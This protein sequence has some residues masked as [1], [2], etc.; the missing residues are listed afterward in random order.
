[1]N[2]E[3][4]VSK[5]V[6]K[7]LGYVLKFGIT[8]YILWRI[9][10]KLDLGVVI[11]SI[12]GQPLWLLL[13]LLLISVL[14][15]GGHC[16]NWA[17]ALRINPLYKSDWKE[18]VNSYLIGQPLRFVLPGGFG[19]AGMVLF[20][21]NSSL[22]ATIL[23]Y[24]M[25]RIFLLWGTLVFASIS[26]SFL[27]V[28]IPLWLRL[29]AIVIV[30]S[31][32]VWIYLILGANRRWRRLR[33]NYV[34][35]TPRILIVQLVIV[36]LFYFQYWLMLQRIMPIK[37]DETVMRMSLTHVISSIPITVAGLG[38]RESFAIHFLSDAGFQ[39]IE[40]VTTTLTIFIIHDI[41]FAL[42]GSVFLIRA[43]QL[44]HKTSLNGSD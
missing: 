11:A 2:K 23:S 36:L 13:V 43:K 8:G 9:F 41:I 39:A 21:S 24:V 20:I 37:F 28:N 6:V 27:F 31:A 16:L 42:I 35:F 15:H 38:L 14:R 1:M 33:K 3:P 17:N 19:S 5:K 7:I 26:A 30:I 40:A 44:G 10:S 4:H 12:A 25:E 32:P 29:T 22:A 34:K 18:I